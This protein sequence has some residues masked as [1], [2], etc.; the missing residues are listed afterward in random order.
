MRAE[1]VMIGCWAYPDGR[2]YPVEIDSLSTEKIN[3]MFD[4][5]FEPVPLT[6]SIL[7]QNGWVLANGVWVLKSSPRLGWNSRTKEL[8][9]GYYTFPATIEYVH[10]LQILMRMLGVEETIKL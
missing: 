1:E 10:Q 7:E 2:S 6:P 4:A 9:T 5:S 8:I 3:G